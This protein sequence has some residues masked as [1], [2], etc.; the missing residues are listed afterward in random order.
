MGRDTSSRKG[1]HLTRE[2]LMVVE[3]MSRG[4]P[5]DI[6]EVPGRHPRT[7]ERELK[8]GRV[9]HMDTEL[10]RALLGIGNSPAAAWRQTHNAI[11]DV[12]LLDY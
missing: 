8:R 10:R 7:I 11:G 9:K 1:K 6:A 5:R 2:E 3:R 4:G 12:S